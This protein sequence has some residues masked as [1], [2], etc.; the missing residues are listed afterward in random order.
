MIVTVVLI[1]ILF[2][3]YYLLC[4]NHIKIQNKYT[5][6]IL[7]IFLSV[8]LRTIIPTEINKDYAGYFE[9][10]N[11]ENPENL[12][13]FLI[14]EP[15]LYG[16]FNFFQLFTTNKRIVIENI[17][18]FN[19]FISL[20]FYVWLAFKKDIY[21][22]KKVIIFVFYYFLTSYVVLRNAPVYF[23]Y[24]YF[25]YYSFRNLKYKRII[26]TPLMHISSVPLLILLFYKN[27]RYYSYLFLA[28]V[29]FIPILITI[30]LPII[31]SVDEIRS[32]LD[33]ADVYAEGMAEVGIFHKIYFCFISGI[34]ILGWLNIKEKIYHP[35]IIT[36]FIIYYISFFINPVIGFRFSPYIILAILLNNFKSNFYI[37]GLNK[38]LNFSI[39]ILLPYFIFTFIDTHHL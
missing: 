35:L 31:E 25:F 38:F 33:K 4:Q 10:Y 17:Y 11:F 18:L 32:S 3:N 1:S 36:T 19:L 30:V 29:I 2:F 27:K 34:L 26:F 28:L 5:Y 24:A 20:Y 6:V 14:S 37:P 8:F 12:A 9:L 21:L 39:I 16:L 23:I 15:Y 22:W 13:T 7:F